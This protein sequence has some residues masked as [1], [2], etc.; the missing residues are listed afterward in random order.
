FSVDDGNFQIPEGGQTGGWIK[1]IGSFDGDLTNTELGVGGKKAN[2]LAESPRQSVFQSPR[3]V[4]GPTDLEFREG[5]TRIKQNFRNIDVKLTASKLKLM[6]GETSR[7]SL[8]VSGLQGIE[9]EVPLHIS[10]TGSA[11]MQGGNIQNL[12]I[13]PAQVNGEGQ[14]LQSRA[15]VGNKVGNFNVTATVLFNAGPVVLNNNLVHVER[16]ATKKWGNYWGVKVKTLDGKFK[17]I[18]FR[19]KPTDAVVPCKWIMITDSEVESDGDIIVKGFQPADDPNKPCLLENKTVHV[20]GSPIQ[21]P[22]GRWQIT[23]TLPNGEKGYI[24]LRSPKKPDLKLCN[25]IKVSGCKKLNS[26]TFEVDGYDVTEDPNKP[27]PP[28]PVYTPTPTPK[29]VPAPVTTPVPKVTPCPEG[30]KRKEKSTI[31]EFEILSKG[32][33]LSFSIEMNNGGGRAAAAGMAAWLGGIKKLGDV[34]KGRFLPD[35]QALGGGIADAALTYVELGEGIISALA[36]SNLG[37]SRVSE[38]SATLSTK[39]IKVTATCTKFEICEDGVWRNKQTYSEERQLVDYTDTITLQAHND[40]RNE[41]RNVT[42]P[43]TGG[44]DVDRAEKYLMK[45]LIEKLKKNEEAYGK[46]KKD[47]K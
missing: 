35:D 13:S 9:D 20:E 45:K 5:N 4:I 25:W 39:L 30:T 3:D 24:N 17:W 37:N 46:F 44:F 43:S 16:V 21:L 41:W 29:P 26:K 11:D 38:V 47:C 10:C 8:N 6:K 32:S 2:P 42:D 1:M 36:K 34:L 22:N 40:P 14:F 12:Q 19:D 18:Y 31:K 27:K 23:I 15:L 7:V 33:Q 28:A